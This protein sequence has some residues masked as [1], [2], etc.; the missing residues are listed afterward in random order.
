MRNVSILTAMLAAGLIASS[1]GAATIVNGSFELGTD[2]GSGFSTEGAGS[3]A[4]TGWTVGGFGVDYIGGYWQAADGVRSVDLS[5]LS[6]GSISQS[7]AT[8]IGQTYTVGFDLSGNPDGGIGNKIAVSTISGSLPIISVYN[9]GAANSRSNMDWQHFT[10]SFTAFS[11]L[12]SL[13]FASAEY[14]PFGPAID[15][16]SIDGGGG[17]GSDVPEPASWAMMIA[18]FGLV[19]LSARRRRPHSVAA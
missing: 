19:G 12:S 7:I 5:A 1:A 17:I 11:A 6:A 13:T 9:V 10:Y 16:I 3:T 14:S 18:G 8:V 4:I 15:N 2:P